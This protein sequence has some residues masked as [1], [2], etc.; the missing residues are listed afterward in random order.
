[1]CFVTRSE[2]HADRPRASAGPRYCD[3]RASTCLG[4]GVR[5]SAQLPRTRSC[6]P[7]S[8]RICQRYVDLRAPLEDAVVQDRNRDRLIGR[9]SIGETHRLAHRRIVGN[10]RR[11][12]VTRSERHADRTPASPALPPVRV[13]LIFALPPASATVYVAALSCNAP[14]G[15]VS[16]SVIVSTAVLGFPSV[17]PPVGFVS[18]MLTVSLPSKTLSSRIGIETVLLAVSPSV[19]LTVWLTAV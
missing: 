1:R 18:A 6:R 10:R 2:R 4:H 11:C 17:A 13:T 9:I 3:R 8:R 15:A 7:S 19:K 5:R 14:A 12:S 16:L